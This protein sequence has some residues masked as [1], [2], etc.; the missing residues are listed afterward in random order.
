MGVRVLRARFT[1]PRFIAWV[2]A[3]YGRWF[4]WVFAAVLLYT[5]VVHF[6]GW[7]PFQHS[8]WL[9]AGAVYLLVAWPGLCRVYVFHTL[10][11]LVSEDLEA[12]AQLADAGIKEFQSGVA[13]GRP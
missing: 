8:D 10:H 5:A 2:S 3:F 9:F 11:R 12:R 4:R 13:G 7:K 1:C 6:S